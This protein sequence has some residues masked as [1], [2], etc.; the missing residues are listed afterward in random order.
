MNG[1]IF[2]IIYLSEW[3]MSDISKRRDRLAD[4]EIEIT[5]A[6][7][8]SRLEEEREFL[9]GGDLCDLVKQVY[10]AMEC[11]RCGLGG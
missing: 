1:I 11:E 6:M 2:P 8:Q 10:L 9:L 3:I 7:G 4:S 5:P